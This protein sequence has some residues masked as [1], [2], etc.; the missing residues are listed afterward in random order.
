MSMGMDMG[1]C[2]GLCH[3]WRW[4]RVMSTR[5]WLSLTTILSLLADALSGGSCQATT[6]VTLLVKYN[7]ARKPT[8]FQSENI[9]TAGRT[10]LVLLQ[11]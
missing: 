6:R 9:S 4:W 3:W 2:M 10:R 8:S 1:L 5:G 7:Q 11:P